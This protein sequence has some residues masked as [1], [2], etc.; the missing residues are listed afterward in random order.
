MLAWSTHLLTEY[1]TA[2]DAAEDET[3]AIANAVERATEPAGGGGGH[4]ERG[5]AERAAT[6]RLRA[7]ARAIICAARPI[8]RR[9]R[10]V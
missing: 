10:S 7:M 6:A 1:V 5:A 4:R 8:H 2:V 3:A 9:C